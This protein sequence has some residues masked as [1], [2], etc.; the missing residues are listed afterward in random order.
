MSASQTIKTHPVLEPK[1][2]Y[3]HKDFLVLNKPAGLLTHGFAQRASSSP[4]LTDWLLRHYPE[5][6]SVGDEPEKRPGIVHRLDKETSGVLL[7][8]RNQKA[9]QYFKKLFQDRQVKKNY[10]ALV[11]GVVKQGT[12]L[13]NKPLGI[14]SGSVKRTVFIKHAKMVKE[15]VTQ[16]KVLRVIGDRYTLLAVKPL[17]GRT[18]QIRVHLASIGHPV[19]GDK[20]YGAKRGVADTE[21]HFL[22]AESLEFSAPDGQ[23]LKISAEP[24]E[25]WQKVLSP[26]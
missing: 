2:I 4:T 23:R 15:A 12:G 6:K 5:V 9:Y 10:L 25:D 26:K 8:T 7:V 20:L 13:I 17:T 3:E 22:H 21:R 16:Y 18:H 11:W 14:K 19:V 1:V 24:P